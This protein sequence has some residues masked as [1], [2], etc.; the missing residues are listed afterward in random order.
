MVP[1]KYA[2]HSAVVCRTIASNLTESC[3][4]EMGINIECSVSSTEMEEGSE[5]VEFLNALRSNNRTKYHCL[6]QG[7]FLQ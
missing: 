5:R 6:L 2:D 4:M 1:C 7:K 3:P